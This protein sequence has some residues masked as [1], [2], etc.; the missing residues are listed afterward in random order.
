M[1]HPDALHVVC[2]VTLRFDSHVW[3]RSQVCRFCFAAG[4]TIARVQFILASGVLACRCW[5]RHLPTLIFHRRTA[6]CFHASAWMVFANLF[7]NKRYLEVFNKITT[8]V[9]PLPSVNSYDL[10]RPSGPY[11]YAARALPT[12]QVAQP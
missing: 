8:L 5:S 10:V 1:R 11:P 7:R 4:P 6:A 9:A 2:A 3:W 12:N